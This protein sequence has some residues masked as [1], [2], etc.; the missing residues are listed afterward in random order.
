[1][2]YGI[3]KTRY[4]NC[5]KNY[6]TEF[7]VYRKI[8]YDIGMVFCHTVT[9]G[10]VYGM[11]LTVY[12]IRYDTHSTVYLTKPSLLLPACIMLV[13]NKSK[14]GYILIYLTLYS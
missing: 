14:K 12:G 6:L 9:F 1:M 3:L 13:I 7:P 2:R 5:I 11:T 8:R 4:G 10:I